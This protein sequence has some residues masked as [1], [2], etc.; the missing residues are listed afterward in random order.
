MLLL[1]GILRLMDAE[2]MTCRGPTWQGQNWGGDSMVKM[3]RPLLDAGMIEG[4][5]SR[6]FQY[7]Q[8]LY[9]VGLYKLKSVASLRQMLTVPSSWRQIGGE[10]I[11]NLSPQVGFSRTSTEQVMLVVQTKVR[12]LLPPRQKS[13]NPCVHQVA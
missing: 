1:A 11:G 12:Q 2:N 9:R 6:Q 3:E 10:L 8:A 5:S 13:P 4:S 7:A